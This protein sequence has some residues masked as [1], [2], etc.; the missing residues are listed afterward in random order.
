MLA[1][2]NAGHDSDGRVVD[3]EV[4]AV[5]KSPEQ[6]APQAAVND[7]VDEGPRG[8]GV[9]ARVDGPQEVEP[10]TGGL[11]L[12]PREGRFEVRLGER[13]NDEPPH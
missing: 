13:S 7:R 12:V 3:V 6:G 5:G 2:V 10:E 4:H 8:N 9:N 1:T 11:C